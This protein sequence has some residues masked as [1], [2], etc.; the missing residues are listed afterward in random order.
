MSEGLG[1]ADA[2]SARACCF[3]PS[4]GVAWDAMPKN[5]VLAASVDANHR[6]DLMIVGQERHVRCPDHVE[7]GQVIRDVEF[8]RYQRVAA[9]PPP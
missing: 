8:S 4:G 5:I 3:D 6:P 2:Q 1:V 9:R 7:N